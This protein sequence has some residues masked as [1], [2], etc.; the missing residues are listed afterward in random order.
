MAI[1]EIEMVQKFVTY[2]GQPNTRKQGDRKQG[3]RGQM[4]IHRQQE[5]S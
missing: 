2:F 4:N 3:H 1:F 5:N